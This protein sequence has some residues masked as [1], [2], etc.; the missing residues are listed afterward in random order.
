MSEFGEL[1]DLVEAALD[2][3]FSAAAYE[4]FMATMPEEHEVLE[5]LAQGSERAVRDYLCEHPD[6]LRPR[7]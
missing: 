5:A 6:A 2:N 4:L 7:G 1:A 3:A